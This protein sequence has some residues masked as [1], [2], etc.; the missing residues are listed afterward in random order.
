[1]KTKIY[2]YNFTSNYGALLQAFELGNYIRSITDSE[3]SFSNYHPIRYRYYEFLRPMVTKKSKKFFG[4]LK[5][6]YK[7][8]L[9]RIKNK[10]NLK[11]LPDN[12][13]D[14]DEYSI[15]GSDEIW[16]FLNPYYG[17]SEYFFGKDDN[18]K[19]IAYAVSIGKAT[20][21]DLDNFQKDK[22][23]QHLK[24]FHSI[25]VR[26]DNTANFVNRLIGVNPEIV[27][28]PTLLSNS[29]IFNNENFNFKKDFV[30]VYGSNFSLNEQQKIIEFSK[31]KNL[32]VV[33]VG[34]FNSWI[35]NNKLGLNP[36]EFF[37]YIKNSKFVFTSMFHGI[38]LSIKSNTNF[39]YTLD[40]I[41]KFKVSYIISK[42]NLDKRL[43]LEMN[44]H[45]ENIDFDKIN[46]S[47]REWVQ[48]SQN[49]LK[50]AFDSKK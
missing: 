13:L 36:S 33:S 14:K 35:S 27:V 16:N 22:I 2:T 10:K 45:D 20:Y 42:F 23:R 28:D 32:D 30:L 39:W 34:Y 5:K 25:S 41:R 17:F 48:K 40:P 7:I 49:F 46:P 31:K 18:K 11:F 4:H 9:W 29:N 6:N 38:I 3:V 26:D 21:E 8:L 50:N 43:I 15:Y 47:L 1:M 12:S 44:K 37:E 19:K 24:K